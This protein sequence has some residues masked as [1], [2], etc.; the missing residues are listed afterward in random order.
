MVAGRGE[1]RGGG[2]VVLKQVVEQTRDTVVSWPFGAPV[3]NSAS[4][5]RGTAG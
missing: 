1:G 5:R 4:E 2:E 3:V